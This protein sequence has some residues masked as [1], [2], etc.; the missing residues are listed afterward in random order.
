MHSTVTPSKGAA[1]PTLG[2]TSSRSPSLLPNPGWGLLLLLPVGRPA[3]EEAGG[4]LP[5]AS[6]SGHSGARQA[7]GLAIHTCPQKR[8]FKVIFLFNCYPAGI[9]YG[10]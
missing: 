6:H 10:V 4:R 1:L 2:P 3:L 5:A 7:P 9:Q 8:Y